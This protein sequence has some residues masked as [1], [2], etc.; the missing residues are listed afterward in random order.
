M[1]GL[2]K[3]T[4]TFWTERN[5]ALTGVALLIPFIILALLLTFNPVWLNEIDANLGAI[6]HNMRTAERTQ[7][8]VGITTLGDLWAQAAFAGIITLIL[9]AVRRWQEAIWFALTVGVGAGLLNN[10]VKHQFARVRPDY[11]EHLVSESHYAFPSGHSMGAMILLGSLLFIVIRLWSSE[12][13]LHFLV[14][15]VCIVTIVAIGLSR[16]YLGVHFPSD[17]LAGFSLGASWLFISIA[18]FGLRAVK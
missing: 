17:V 15:V 10:F 4:S 11:I 13:I 2:T 18:T 12:A 7:I 8:V 6:L 1:I 16:I 14:S 5:T 9:L 3:R